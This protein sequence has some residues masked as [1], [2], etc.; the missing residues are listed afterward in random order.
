MHVF[1]EG[2]DY[3]WLGDRD[4]PRGAAPRPGWSAILV[5]GGAASAQEE[6]AAVRELASVNAWIHGFIAP[7]ALLGEDDPLIVGH[8][9]NV[10]IA[11]AGASGRL[12]LDLLVGAAGWAN[13]LDVLGDDE[14]RSVVLDHCGGGPLGSEQW[15]AFVTAAARFPHAMVKI[16]AAPPRGVIVLLLDLFGA[17]R[18]MFGSDWPV[19]R[20]DDQLKTLLSV[21]GASTTEARAVLGANA[22]RVYG[23]LG[24]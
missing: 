24:G 22:E 10:A 6:V 11:A 15:R 4:V 13:A 14:G 18:M 5:E 2:I 20:E 1:V 23:L 9:A 12:P 8:R 7:M 21:L 3:P 19:T 17:E 16:S